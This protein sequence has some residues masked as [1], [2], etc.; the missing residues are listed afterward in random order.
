[1]REAF[2]IHHMESD[3]DDG[4]V[5]V[6]EWD[7]RAVTGEGTGS[8]VIRALVGGKPM[9]VFKTYTNSSAAP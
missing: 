3:E 8:V 6:V 7:G 2:N 9:T 4:G 1:M 5:V